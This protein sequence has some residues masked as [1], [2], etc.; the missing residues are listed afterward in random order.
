VCHAIPQY[1]FAIRR[2]PPRSQHVLAIL[3]HPMPARTITVQPI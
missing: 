3:S 2:H 1:G